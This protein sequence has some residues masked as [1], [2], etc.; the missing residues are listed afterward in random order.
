MS[1][2]FFSAGKALQITLGIIL[3]GTLAIFAV[4]KTH[5]LVWG[6]SIKIESPKNGS[7]LSSAFVVIKGVAPDS[8]LLTVNGAKVLT[9]AVGNFEKELLLGLGYNM[10]RVDSLDRF[11]RERNQTLELVY[12]PKDSATSSVAFKN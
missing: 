2:N 8:A 4:F 11:N 7:T 12:R 5:D 9:D 1:L 10:I 3:V 6:A